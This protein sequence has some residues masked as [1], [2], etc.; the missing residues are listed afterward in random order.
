MSLRELTYTEVI[1]VFKMFFGCS[2]WKCERL[3]GFGMKCIK[4]AAR[5]RV[6]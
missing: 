2:S 4:S 5:D 1:N 3:S 6:I